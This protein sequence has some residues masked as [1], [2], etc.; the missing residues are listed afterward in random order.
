M[1]TTSFDSDRASAAAPDFPKTGSD[2]EGFSWLREITEEVPPLKNDRGGRWPM[3]LWDDGGGLEPLSVE[4]HQAMLARGIVQHIR[5]D[6][7]MIETAKALQ[8]AGAPVIMVQGSSGTWRYQMGGPESEWAHQFETG[9]APE[10]ERH[11][12]CPHRFAGYA[13]QADVIRKTLRAFKEAGVAVDAVWMDWEDD[14]IPGS[15]P[16]DRYQQASHCR[17]CRAELPP[18]VIGDEKSYLDF[19]WRLYQ[20]LN[21]AYLAGP[22]LEVFPRCS[23]TNWMVLYSTPERTVRHWTDRV[24]APCIPPVFTATNPVAY[25]NDKFWPAAWQEAFPLDREHVDQFYMHLMLRMISDDAANRQRYRP[26]VQSIPWVVRW[27]PDIGDPEIPMMSREAYRESLRHMWLRGVD[28][29]QLFQPLRQGYQHIVKTEVHDAVAIYDEMLAHRAFLDHGE[30]LCTDVPA[31]QD[32]GVVWSGLR[33][34]ERA[35]VRAY[36]QSKGTVA[37]EVRPWPSTGVELVATDA[38]RTYLLE[39]AG[40]EVAVTDL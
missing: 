31:L 8:A 14:P 25:G 21:G 35:V 36:T 24:L 22:A 29:M 34:E 13:V 39:R 28:G 18:E 7:G 11:Y 38:G 6:T 15:T 40:D 12:A 33:L 20:E 5:M 37:F 2:E 26:E 9:Y 30:V 10:S 27:C 17:R 16:G 3:V 4:V 23:V 19:C 32:G 1:A